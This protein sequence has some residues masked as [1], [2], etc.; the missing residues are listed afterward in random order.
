MWLDGKH[1]Q[2]IKIL[3]QLYLLIYFREGEGGTGREKARCAWEAEG[4]GEA[5]N[6]KPTPY[7]AQSPEAGAQSHN[8]KVMTWAETKGRTLNRLRTQAPP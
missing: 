4:E 6:L 3:L 5:E 8:S 2:G 1:F 7:W